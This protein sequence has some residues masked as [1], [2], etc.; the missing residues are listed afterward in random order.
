MY[1]IVSMT[2][3]TS[4]LPAATFHILIALADRPRHGYG[5]LRDIADRTAGE[6]QIGPAT[7]Y[8]SVKRMLESGLIEET[9]FR[10]DAEAD[11]RRRYYRLTSMG[12]Q[13]AVA[14]ANRLESV[15]AHARTRFLRSRNA[16]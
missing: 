12:R 1:H 11:P 13:A 2:R 14:E 9:Y 6:F 5:I 4:P 3:A 15:L 8:T 10:R 16:Q 7:L